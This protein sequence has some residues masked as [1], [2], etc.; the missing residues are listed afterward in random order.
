MKVSLNKCLSY[1]EEDV[2]RSIKAAVDNLGGISSFIKP[3][4]KVLL[5]PNM[6]GA[7]TPDKTVN[8]HPAI[9]K[10]VI[11]LV[12]EAKGIPFIG[13]SPGFDNPKKAFKVSGYNEICAEF[14]EFKTPYDL[15]IANSRRFK[16]I[17][18]AKE[19]LDFDVVINLAKLKTHHLTGITCAVKNMFGCIPG[20][21][22]S[23]YHVKLPKKEDF[24]L[25]LLDLID[26]LKPALSIVDA[27]SAM[28]GNGGP[29]SGSPIRLNFIGASQSAQ[30]LDYIICKIININ[31]KDIPT[32]KVDDRF[33]PETIELI[34]E[35][36]EDLFNS[37]FKR[38]ETLTPIFPGPAFLQNIL[39]K[40]ISEKP[41]L[42][43]NKCTNCGNCYKICLSKAID[44]SK[45]YPIFNYDKCINCYCCAE[46]CPSKA[47]EIKA[48]NLIMLLQRLYS[49]IR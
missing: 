47:I 13:D 24:C 29:V 6:L 2:Y 44:F 43:K 15:P 38:I 49:R 42:L 3:N 32:I 28:E 10:A 46:M 21:L 9:L 5:K 1:A 17:T 4:Q 33:N 36:I 34:G 35:K 30:A 8:T 26:N 23:G 18:I 11:R 14:I 12:K 45:K 22:K 37:N 48:N 31:P 19:I 41:M 27:V 40:M 20:I 7:H 39:N 16:T 25:M